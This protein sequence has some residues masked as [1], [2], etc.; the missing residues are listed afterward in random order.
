MAH[1]GAEQLR[2]ADT[3]TAEG[4]FCVAHGDVKVDD[5]TTKEPNYLYITLPTY[6][7]PTINQ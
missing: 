2:A 5:L 4:N 1:P 3:E 6:V 7:P